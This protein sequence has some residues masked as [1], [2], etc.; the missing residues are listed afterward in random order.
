MNRN[1]EVKEAEWRGSN[2]N[3]EMFEGKKRSERGRE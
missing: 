2:R 3:I 1:A